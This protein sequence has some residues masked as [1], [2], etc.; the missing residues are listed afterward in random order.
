MNGSGFERV[1][2]PQFPRVGIFSGSLGY[3]MLDRLIHRASRILACM[4][5]YIHTYTHIY[6]LCIYTYTHIYMYI[7]I[8]NIYLWRFSS[9]LPASN[10]Q[11]AMGRSRGNS[12]ETVEDGDL[13]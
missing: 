3:S 6:I 4:Y 12:V 11:Q 8:Y 1:A 7:Y 9:R 10:D 13:T 2:P 5:I